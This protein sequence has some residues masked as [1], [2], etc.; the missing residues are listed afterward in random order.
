MRSI[1]DLIDRFARR[2]DPLADRARAMIERRA[3]VRARQL[4]TT[5]GYILRD[6]NW[7]ALTPVLRALLTPEARCLDC[8]CPFVDATGITIDHLEPPRYF[9]DWAREHARNIA[10]VCRSC[11]AMK[12]RKTL[13]IWLE[14]RAPTIGNTWEQLPLDLV[15][16]LSPV[17]RAELSRARADLT[18]P[19]T[20]RFGPPGGWVGSSRN[21]VG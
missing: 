5:K 20:G 8:G 21:D 6:L 4:H 13:A 7:A 16:E 9:Q 17:E 14:E 18:G 11:N 2:G 19:K 3:D 1:T 10:F 15:P 12:Q